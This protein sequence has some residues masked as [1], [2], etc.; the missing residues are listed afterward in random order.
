MQRRRRPHGLRAPARLGQPRLEI[1]DRGIP[2]PRAHLPIKRV[3][4]GRVFC[5]RE[6]SGLM[7]PPFPRLRLRAQMPQQRIE[8]VFARVVQHRAHDP[9][10]ARARR[11]HRGPPKCAHGTAHALQPRLGGLG[12]LRRRIVQDDQARAD[13]CRR[14]DLSQHKARTPAQIHDPVRPRLVPDVSHGLD[15]RPR[16]F[17]VGEISTVDLRPRGAMHDLFAA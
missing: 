14:A 17:R 5:P 1:G 2:F 3:Q 15:Q 13:A 7:H 6:A 8:A 9:Q 16:H 10:D 12:Q 4:A 11:R